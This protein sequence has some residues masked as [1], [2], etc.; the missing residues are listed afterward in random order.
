VDLLEEGS[1]FLKLSAPYRISNM[2]DISDLETVATEILKVAVH[3]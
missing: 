3:I 1:T 2:H